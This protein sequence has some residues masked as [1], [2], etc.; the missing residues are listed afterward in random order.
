MATNTTPLDAQKYVNIETFKKDG[1]GVK[2]PIWAAPLDGKLVFFTNVNSFK[3]KRLGR[4]PKLR[5]AGCDGR[6]KTIHTPWYEA[7]ARRLE[8]AEADAADAALGRKYGLSYKLF[9]VGAALI[10]KKKEQVFFEITIA[11]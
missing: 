3:V 10:G 1:G 4:N 11:A 2:T 6:G 9:R 5:I 8:G 7:T